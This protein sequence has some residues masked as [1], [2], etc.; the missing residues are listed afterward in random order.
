MKNLIL[1]FILLFTLTACSQE[2]KKSE[3]QIA[4]CEKNKGCEIVITKL[5]ENEIAQILKRPDLV[6]SANA[7]LVIEKCDFRNES[8]LTM[9][10]LHANYGGKG[11]PKRITDFDLENY[12]KKNQC[13]QCPNPT[14]KISVKI[15]SPEFSGSSYFFISWDK[16]EAYMPNDAYQKL[17]GDELEGMT[18]DAFLRNHQYASYISH[19]E[20][21]KI[22]NNMPIGM[23]VMNFGNDKENEAKFKRN[24]KATGKKRAHLNTADF[25]YEYLGKDD[26]GNQLVF[27]LGPSYDFCLPP[28]KF[29]ALGF[30]NLGYLAVDGITHTVMEISGPA[31]KFQITA[32]GNGSYN[33]NPAGYKSM[34]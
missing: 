19:P 9:Q 13:L 6:T 11:E 14:K 25:Q 34:N 2:K 15:S 23:S 20:A 3:L 26:E 22:K 31:I 7:I 24:F 5:S 29:D 10:Q 18:V 30:F 1:I 27:W 21:G 33:F 32:I 16:K 4:L 12:L 28:G 17:Y 8:K